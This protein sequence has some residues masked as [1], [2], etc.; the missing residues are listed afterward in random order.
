MAADG[1]ALERLGTLKPID[2]S[3]TA[4]QLNDQLG[5]TRAA[6]QEVAG[7]VGRL[8]ERL[9]KIVPETEALLKTAQREARAE[10]V[11]AGGVADAERRYLREDGAVQ[12]GRTT[13]RIVF[14]G[15][16]GDG[17]DVVRE[18]LLTEAHT[19]CPE[20]EELRRTFVN[21]AAA[22]TVT[23][24]N[25]RSPLLRKS[26]LAFRAAAVEF[27]GKI[28]AYFRDAFAS[29]ES[30]KRVVSNTAGSGAELIGV[31][32]VADV[33]R[34]H[35]IARRVV[36]LVPELTVA[37][38]SF[39]APIVTGRSLSKKRGATTDDPAAYPVQTWTTSDETF[40]VVDRVAQ[41]VVDD[42]YETEGALVSA[43]P[44][45]DVVRW[46][47]SGDAD[48]LEIAFIHGDTAGTHQDTINTWTLGNYY[49]AGALGGSA[50]PAKHWIGFRARA[51]DDSA[52][53]A[54]GGSF[55]SSDH[56]GA[57]ALMGPLGANAV[58]LTGLYA[59]YTQLL[60]Y[61]SFTTVDKFGP[62]ATLLTGTLGR[63]GDT[64]VVW[65]QFL[66]NEYASTGLYTGS[67]TTS[68][69]VYFQPMAWRHYAM[70]GADMA[71][72]VSR[73]ER[74]ARY[75]GIKRRSVL[76]PWTVSGEKPAAVI[77]NV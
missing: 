44:M 61:S 28:G 34:P 67:G 27:P 3:V 57:L 32:T 2:G 75:L 19:L 43:D 8:H 46:L 53:V 10:W 38:S 62:N 42:N 15:T 17:V 65:S 12:L 33:R 56:Y 35:D 29:V 77:I 36:G 11:P 70:S 66:A 9:A 26:F 71:W 48:T 55:D 60:N 59:Y 73:E 74:G 58:M 63:I 14:P 7:D 69:L 51:F 45:G 4:A 37:Q 16:D 54:G 40:T 68:T 22:Y 5:T 21:Y 20:H 41:A 39:K 24:R 13:T 49:S 76:K 50:S 47:E 64:S 23:R 25:W 6:V 18:G 31:P 1:S 52:T 30:L 72:D